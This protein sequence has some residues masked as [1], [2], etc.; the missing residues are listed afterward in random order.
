MREWWTQNG[1]GFDH[2]HGADYLKT[3]FQNKYNLR[4]SVITKIGEDGLHKYYQVHGY[5]LVYL[6]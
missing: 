4:H 2:A 5:M 1:L 3:T 6:E